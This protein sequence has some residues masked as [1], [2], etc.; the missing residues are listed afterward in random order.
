MARNALERS[1]T[2]QPDCLKGRVVFRTVYGDMHL[3][4]ILGSFVRVGYCIPVSDFYLVLHSLPK[5]QYNG[6]INQPINQYF[7]TRTMPHQQLQRSYFG[8][9]EFKLEE[10]A[11]V[12]ELG[13][14]ENDQRAVRSDVGAP[15]LVHGRARRVD[16]RTWQHKHVHII[17]YI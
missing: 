10:R 17:I 6:L 1:L 9:E 4:D 7:L 15:R 16:Q 8:G 11:V 13:A 12:Q 5:K 14:G 2:V 3:K